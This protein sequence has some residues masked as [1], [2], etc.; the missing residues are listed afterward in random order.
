[1]INSLKMSNHFPFIYKVE[2][3]YVTCCFDSCSCRQ[4][5]IDVLVCV[6]CNLES[7]CL[8]F[9]YV[10]SSVVVCLAVERGIPFP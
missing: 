4:N 8:H 7:M 6:L 3:S 9:L 5:M 1:M 2:Q 10:T